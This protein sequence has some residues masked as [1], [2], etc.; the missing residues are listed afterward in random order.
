V[1]SC[2]TTD[3]RRWNIVRSGSA[4]AFAGGGKAGRY[5]EM[6]TTVGARSRMAS[7]IGWLSL[8]AASLM[9]TLAAQ[10]SRP[11]FEVA[12]VKK[13]ERPAPFNPIRMR[14]RSA[15]FHLTNSTVASL[16]QFAYDAMEFAV[17][18]GP[19]WIRRDQ[20]EISARAAAEVSIDE[21]RPMVQSLLEER[22]RLVVRTEQR[23]MRFFALVVAR[24]DRRLGP[25][26][27][28]C[29]VS[30]PSKKVRVPPTGRM[31]YVR[32]APISAVANLAAAVLRMPVVDRTGLM[33]LWDHVIAFES[34]PRATVPA[35]GD[36]PQ[37][38]AVESP[39]TFPTAL[40]E[41]LG[42]RLEPDRGPVDVLV[43]ASVQQPSEN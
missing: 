32:C 21:M 11:A 22:F 9:T 28:A 30:D 14:P 34:P 3:I 35:P 10:S 31:S 16:I 38:P 13:L 37:Q 12:S 41:Q 43:V 2:A 19:E 39:P 33:G 18:G 6:K 17:I 20:F 26:L 40:Q 23:E 15:A 25:G 7:R 24:D 4:E 27:T 1:F 5:M 36:G 29:D 42:L 8:V